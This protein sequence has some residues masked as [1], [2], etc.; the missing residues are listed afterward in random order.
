[1]TADPVKDWALHWYEKLQIEA[2]LRPITPHAPRPEFHRPQGLP[3][4]GF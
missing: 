1:M 3:R 2:W 4:S